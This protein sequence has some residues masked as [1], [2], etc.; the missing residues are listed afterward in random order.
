MEITTYD[1]IMQSS[2]TI[3]VASRISHTDNII[4]RLTYALIFIVKQL[5]WR[6]I[7]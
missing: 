1:C 5:F 3:G 4:D 2:H 7:E 6:L